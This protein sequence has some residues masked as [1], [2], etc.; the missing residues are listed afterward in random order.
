VLTLHEDLTNKLAHWKSPSK[1]AIPQYLVVDLMRKSIVVKPSLESARML[2]QLEVPTQLYD[3]KNE[4]LILGASISYL[5]LRQNQATFDGFFWDGKG[6]AVVFQTIVNDTHLVKKSSLEWL[7]KLDGVSRIWYIAVTPD[8]ATVD[9]TF[10]EGVK[11][12]I[13]DGQR[14]QIRITL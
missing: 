1:H 10:E 11:S 8:D 7:S 12:M 13:E 2:L 14:Y 5:P 9:F 4:E 3:V 6:L